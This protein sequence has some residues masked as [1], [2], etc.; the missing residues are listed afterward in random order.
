MLAKIQED[1]E[2]ADNKKEI[3]AKE[4]AEAKI[5]Q[6][7][8]AELAE[9]VKAEV[10]EADA[11]LSKTLEKIGLLNPGHLTEI[12]SFTDPPTKVK[13]VFMA[14][15]VLMMPMNMLTTKNNWSDEEVEMHFWKNVNPTG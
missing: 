11:E 5:A 8:A 12:K 13:Y 9:K 14:T 4:E 15:C 1:K 6:K 7:E 3:V 10:D 2:I